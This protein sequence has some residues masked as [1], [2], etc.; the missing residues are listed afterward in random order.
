MRLVCASQA[1]AGLFQIHAAAHARFGALA[2]L[3]ERFFVQRIVLARQQLHVAVA[4]QVDIGLGGGQRG[5]VAGGQHVI[6]AGQLVETGLLDVIA[7]AEAVEN[8]LAQFQ[9]VARRLHCWEPTP[10]TLLRYSRPT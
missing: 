7:G 5:G 8:Q 3:L 4:L 10:G 2:D 6:E 1:A 9:V